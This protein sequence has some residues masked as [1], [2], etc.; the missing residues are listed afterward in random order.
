MAFVSTRTIYSTVLHGDRTIQST[1]SVNEI[2]RVQHLLVKE[3]YRVWYLLV[4]AIHSRHTQQRSINILSLFFN[5]LHVSAL[6]WYLNV[7][8]KPLQVQYISVMET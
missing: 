3:L 6:M 8:Y 7:I 5:L 1:V 4:R 2:Y